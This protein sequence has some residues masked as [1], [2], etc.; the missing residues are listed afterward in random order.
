MSPR[1]SLPLATRTL[2]PTVLVAVL[3]GATFAVMLLAVSAFREA[4]RREANSRNVTVAT[5]RAEQLVVDLEAGLRG[6]VLTRN[7]RFETSLGKTRD[8]LQ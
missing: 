3:V 8:G 6:F 5:L 7:P 1:H 4:E 2:F